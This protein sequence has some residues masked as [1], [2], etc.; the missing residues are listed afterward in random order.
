MKASSLRDF[1]KSLRIQKSVIFAL[2]M[3]EIITRYGRHNIGVAWLILEPMLFTLGVATLWSLT[4]MSSKVG[5]SIH[6][7]ALTGY[8]TVLLWRNAVNRCALAI[9]SN[10]PL[11]FHRNVKVIDVY[12][13]RCI[14]EFCG[15][16]AAIFILTIAF[17]FLTGD[18][19]PADLNRVTIAWLLLG[20]FAIALA[21]IVG[22]LSEMSEVIDRIWHVATYLFFPLS[23]A[24]YLVAWLPEAVQKYALFLPTVHITEMLRHGYAGDLIKT[25]EDPIYVIKVNLVMTLIGL[26]LVLVTEKNVRKG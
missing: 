3:R 20:W 14:L 18:S 7:F 11:L 19:P 6:I 24:A 9:E 8:S 10:L 25:Y 15:A 5:M 4:Q 13:S 23:G 1:Y 26:L 12:L 16:T 2:L 17:T 22:S 21:F